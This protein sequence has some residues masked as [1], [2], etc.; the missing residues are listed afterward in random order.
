MSDIVPAL[1]AE[2]AELEADL[3][4]NPDPRVRKLQ[5]LRDTLIE[6]EPKRNIAQAVANIP[7]S[8]GNG[9]FHELP[10]ALSASLS[11]A[12]KTVKMRLYIGNLL[13]QRG[14]VHR[15]ELLESL[16]AARI[17]G[18]EK[19]PMQA[20]AIFLS[21]HKELFEFDGS[22]NYKLREGAVLIPQR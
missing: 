19:D 20:L 8:N 4:A 13:R 9:A 16:I 6:Y 1:K 10:A 12:T 7:Q 17:M 5:K 3:R 14:S 11:A 18:S 2:I 21:S 15:K 22:G